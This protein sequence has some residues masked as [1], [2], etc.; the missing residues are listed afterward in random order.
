MCACVCA[1]VL[2][3]KGSLIKLR[4][5]F[6]LPPR[7]HEPAIKIRHLEPW[8]IALIV[9]GT[10]V[11]AA[12]TIALLVYFLAYGKFYITQHCSDV[13]CISFLLVVPHGA[14]SL[15]FISLSKA[16]LGKTHRL[17]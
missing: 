10:V 6:L 9:I 14:G 11:A 4:P 17:L 5:L 13:Y 3:R 1:S 2:N 12:I 8:K 15:L 7:I 16:H